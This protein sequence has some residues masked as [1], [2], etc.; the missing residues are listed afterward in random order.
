MPH[1]RPIS[2]TRLVRPWSQV[3]GVKRCVLPIIYLTW[4]QS[5]EQQRLATCGS[6]LLLRSR[7]TRLTCCSS[8]SHSVK[9]ASRSIDDMRQAVAGTRQFNPYEYSG[10]TEMWGFCV[11]VCCSCY[12]CI[13][14][15]QDLCGFLSMRNKALKAASTRDR[16]WLLTAREQENPT[17]GNRAYSKY[18]CPQRP[19]QEGS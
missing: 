6:I 9:W 16:K 11:G 2:R 8:V 1:S 13:E 12:C 14:H 17:T 19:G 3:P 15:S 18:Y 4:Y 5:G 10:Y 7:Q